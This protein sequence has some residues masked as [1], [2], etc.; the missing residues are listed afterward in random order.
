MDMTERSVSARQFVRSVLMIIVS[1]AII[2]GVF[3]LATA[4]TL[5]PSSDTTIG[6]LNSLASISDALF[7]SFDSSAIT[8]DPNGSA[9]QVT[10]C[11]IVRINGGTCP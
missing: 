1:I 8:A 6:T 5:N 2:I 9:L 4:G 10:K 3:R 7:G 11:I